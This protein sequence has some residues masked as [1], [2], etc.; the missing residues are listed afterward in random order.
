MEAGSSAMKNIAAV[1]NS[2]TEYES[3]K[4]EYDEN[5]FTNDPYCEIQE[6]EWGKKLIWTPP[7]TEYLGSEL[8]FA[9]T[10][11]TGIHKSDRFRILT[12]RSGKAWIA[13]ENENGQMRET[14]MPYATGFRIQPGQKYSI[15]CEGE[16]KII[17]GS[18]RNPREAVEKGLFS[19]DA[20]VAVDDTKPWGCEYIFS[21]T[22][23]DPISM[24]ILHVEEDEALSLQA[25][26]KKV[27]SYYMS[28]GECDMVMENTDRELIT[29][30]LEYDKGYTTKVGQRHRH[31]GATRMDV[32]EVSTPEDKKYKTW[33]LAD[34]Y[35]R[36]DQV[37]LEAER[38]KI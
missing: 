8:Q 19:T 5:T 3:R 33:R 7:N 16:T 10:K 11:A 22:H 20:Y 31:Q 6:T 27:E 17:E 4:Y 32:F 12:F 36:G 14:E 26:E 25:H 35:A 2:V 34:K 38:G 15:R 37:D 24:K 1:E 28:Y 13:L 21:R 9:E 30:K 23:E 29:F 18:E